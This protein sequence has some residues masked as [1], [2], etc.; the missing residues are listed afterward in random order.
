[1]VAVILRVVNALESTRHKV[2]VLFVTSLLI[3]AVFR[4]AMPD[5]RKTDSNTDYAP[6]VASLLAG[7]AVALQPVV[8]LAWRS[9]EHAPRG[10]GVAQHARQPTPS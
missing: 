8:Q 7:I 2:L 9:A 5:S 10:P 6:Q 3:S 1:M 4:L